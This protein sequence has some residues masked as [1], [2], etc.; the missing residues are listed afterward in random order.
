MSKYRKEIFL[1]V[2]FSASD[3]L[4]KELRN[5]GISVRGMGQTRWKNLITVL[6]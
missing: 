6:W 2:E 5:M 3:N 1:C 4:A